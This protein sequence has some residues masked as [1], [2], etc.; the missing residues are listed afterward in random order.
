MTVRQKTKSAKTDNDT[1]DS[2]PP[3]PVKPTVSEPKVETPPSPPSPRQEEKNSPEKKRRRTST[4]PKRK[5]GF[6]LGPFHL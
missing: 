6:H 5:G 1:P 4:A 3:A 2:Q